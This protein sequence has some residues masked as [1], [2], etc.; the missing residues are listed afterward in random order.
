MLQCSFDRNV[1]GDSLCPFASLCIAECEVPRDNCFVVDGGVSAFADSQQGFQFAVAA[2]QEEIDLAINRGEFNDID[3]RVVAMGSLDQPPPTPAPTIDREGDGNSIPVWGYVLIGCGAFALVA[4]G[5]YAA[6]RYRNQEGKQSLVGEDD[7]YRGTGAEEDA[8][9]RAS[10][11][12]YNYQG[13]AGRRSTQSNAMALDAMEE[14]SDSD[15]EDEPLSRRR[16]SSGQGDRPSTPVD[17]MASF[18]RP[19][20]ADRSALLESLNGG[21]VSPEI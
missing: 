16:S 4:G 11:S 12:G 6:T 18:A 1:H 13:S 21:G 15:S 2:I 9:Y 10:G 14:E 5:V 19:S 3:S 20:A 17:P 7:F 8:G